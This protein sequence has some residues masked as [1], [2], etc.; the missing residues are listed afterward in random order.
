LVLRLAQ[1]GQLELGV[2][3]GSEQ[4]AEQTIQLPARDTRKSDKAADKERSDIARGRRIRL[5]H[6]HDHDEDGNGSAVGVRTT[7]RSEKERTS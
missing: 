3:L 4:P 2:Q 6:G 1:D 7:E 5:T